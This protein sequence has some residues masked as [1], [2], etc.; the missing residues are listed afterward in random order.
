MEIVKSL[1]TT[2]SKNGT[3]ISQALFWC[4]YCKKEVIRQR[5]SGLR[6]DSCCMGSKKIKK[7]NAVDRIC[8]G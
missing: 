5:S 3:Y 7:R 4:P 6:V 2:K 1:H 8:L